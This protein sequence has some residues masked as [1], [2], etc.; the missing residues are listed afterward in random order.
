MTGAPRTVAGSTDGELTAVELWDSLRG[1]PPLEHLLDWP[2]DVFAFA[3]RILEAS[4]AYRFVVSPPPGVESDSEESA[5]DLARCWREWLDGD[6][7]AVPSAIEQ[8]WKLIVDAPEVTIDALSEGTPW[9]VCRALLAMHAVADEAC[10]GLGTATAAAAGA[11]RGFRSRARELLAETGSL[12]RISPRVLRVLPRERVGTEGISILSLSRYVCVCSPQIE[13]EWHRIL[14]RPSG[15]GAMSSHANVLLLP[16]PLRVRSSDFRPVPYTL[17]HMDPTRFGF[18]EYGP[19]EPLDLDL[20]DAVLDAAED[21]AGVVDIVGLPEAA[22]LPDEIEPLERVLAAH[23]VWSVIAGVRQAPAEPGTLGASWVHFG[24]RQEMVWRHVTQHKHHRW[25]LDAAQISQY[26]LAGALDPSMSWWEAIAIPRRSLQVVDEGVVTVVPLLCEDLARLQPVTELV[27][28][29]GPSAVIT[30][31]LDGPQLAS[32]WTA[33]YAGVLAD[34]PGT[35]VCTLTSY[36]MVRR[37]RPSGYPP[38]N[39]VA[40]WKD[41]SGGLTE[42]PLDDDA[43]AV[44]IV[45]NTAAG[46]RHTA[47]GRRHSGSQVG[48]TL[49]AVLSVR[50]DGTRGH[51]T[52]ARGPEPLPPGQPLP[53][54]DERELSKATSW[55]EAVAE[56]AVVSPEAVMAALDD[57]VDDRWRHRLHLPPPTHLFESA[58]AALRREL[59]E[60]PDLAAV[61]GAAERLRM[62]THP[63]DVLTGTLLSI[64]LEQRVLTEN[65]ASRLGALEEAATRPR[66][67]R[68]E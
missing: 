7:R 55:A 19:R 66:A 54:L 45:T 65:T 21:E 16:W 48:F 18:F 30:L 42:I 25:R 4:E 56:A 15:I 38:S 35:A 5:A 1:A 29:I 24:V 47:D 26:H 11:G 20:V 17:P 12:S 50:S 57:A 3:N 59:P 52:T 27:R 46:D 58:V 37:C 44:L 23:G 9:P 67:V 2:P 33:R 8:W 34:D 43:H 61:S 53:P 68:P 63:T 39:V 10:A 6:R 28:S 13:V 40:L 32:R 31:L 22:I 60:V 62:S 51:A 36:G 64:A 41:P 14:A 49:A